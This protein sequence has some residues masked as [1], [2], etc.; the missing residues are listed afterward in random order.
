MKLGE[1]PGKHPLGKR[2]LCGEQHYSKHKKMFNLFP[3][4]IKQFHSFSA[5]F[6]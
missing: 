1:S 6:V 3:K 4:F 5:A 2:P